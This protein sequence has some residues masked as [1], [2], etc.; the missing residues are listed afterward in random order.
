MISPFIFWNLWGVGTS[1][2]RLR[3]IIKNYRPKILA[4]V[5]PFLLKD[6]I[7]NYL[8]QFSCEFFVTNEVQGGK[9]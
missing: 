8:G 7:S 2:L 5:E 1:K 6:K 4:L 9:F 3:N